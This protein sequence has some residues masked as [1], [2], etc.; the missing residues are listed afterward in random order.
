[1][2]EPATPPAYKRFMLLGFVFDTTDHE[3]E[4]IVA[5]GTTTKIL[6]ERYPGL[7]K[8][9][10]KIDESLKRFVR[11]KQPKHIPKVD[12]V[13]YDKG[14]AQIRVVLTREEVPVD[15]LLIAL[16]GAPTGVP[17][18]APNPAKDTPSK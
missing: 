3:L 1:M 15:D 14:A 18:P 13:I 11:D 9:L 4:R 6:S 8:A 10:M 7:V 17:N 5:V 12:R 16:E 2:S